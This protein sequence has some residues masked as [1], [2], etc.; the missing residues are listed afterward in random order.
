M[1]PERDRRSGSATY[2]RTAGTCAPPF[3]TRRSNPRGLCR[4]TDAVLGAFD[5]S[6]NA[7]GG[8]SAIPALLPS[9]L[10]LP[11]PARIEPARVLGIAR[12]RRHRTRVVRARGGGVGHARAPRTR[13][14]RDGGRRA[15][16]ARARA[17]RPMRRADD[18][19]GRLSVHRHTLARHCGGRPPDR[20]RRAR[21]WRGRA[22]FSHARSG[23]VVRRMS[24]GDV[25]QHLERRARG[26]KKRN[27]EVC[28]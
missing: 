3:E 9:G 5:G 11:G 14:C 20:A 17:R 6:A 16:P 23:A 4:G 10:R 25:V 18:L 7:F 8:C 21:G 19:S 24:P 2:W 1:D 15:K 28:A 13:R 12:A 26:Q 22:G 27:G